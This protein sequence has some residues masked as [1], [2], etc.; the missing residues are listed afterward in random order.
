MGGR[1]GGKP[2]D[3]ADYFPITWQQPVARPGAFTR[4]GVFND[5]RPRRQ[6]L[7]NDLNGNLVDQTTFGELLLRGIQESA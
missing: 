2:R 1:I 7:D 6:R 4:R 5:L 3:P